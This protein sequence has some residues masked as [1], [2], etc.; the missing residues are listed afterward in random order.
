MKFYLHCVLALMSSTISF[1]A[2]AQS[3][4]TPVYL[5]TFYESVMKMHPEGKLGQVIKKE[6]ISTTIAGARAWRIAYI[7]SDLAGRKTISTGLI[8]APVGRAPKDGR[9]VIAWAHGTTGTAQNCGPSQLPNPAQPLSEYF[10]I[11]GNAGTD[12]G[13]PAVEK[14]IQD[15][16]VVVATDYQGQGGGGKHQYMVSGTQARDAINSIRAAGDMKEIGAG[17]KAMIYGW[18]QGGGTVLAAASSPDYIA[19]K[20]TAFDGIEFVGFVA[21]AP[22]DVSATISARPNDPAIAD[23]FVGQLL[24]TF[25]ANVMD[26]THASMTFWAIPNGF[27]N[28]HLEDIFTPEGAQAMNAIYTGKCIHTAADTITYNYGDT[29]KTLL[30]TKADNTLAWAQAIY[31]SGV[32]KVKPVAP[33]IIFWGTKDTA[34]PPVMGDLYRQQMCKLGANVTRIQLPG[35]QTHYTT[36]PVSE[37]MYVPWVEARFA[38]KPADNGCA[39]LQ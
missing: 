17:K 7:S 12:Y 4:S 15:G 1:F 22:P 24:Q 20:G 9:P 25:S 5:P 35:E 30:K 34:V 13:L 29:Y 18:S 28:T 33:V 38:G 36:P 16:Y 23:Q 39:G 2:S 27:S 8:V 32:A 19:Q 14:F 11:G 10:L 6:S 31:D 3:S 21:L 26:F 37:P